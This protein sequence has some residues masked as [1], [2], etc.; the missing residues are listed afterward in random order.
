MPARPLGASA[1]ANRGINAV[2]PAPAGGTD[3]QLPLAPSDRN[4]LDWLRAFNQSTDPSQYVGQ[5]SEL[6]GFVY[7]D[8]RLPAGQFLLTRFMLTCCVADA[9][10]IGAIVEWPRAA[11]LPTNGW[12]Q[13]GGPVRVGEL[14][15]VQLP[16]IEAETVEA[17]PEPAQPYLY[18]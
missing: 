2:A 11:E 8:P 6:I 13:I 3:A 10:A 1:I 18:N 4:L 9:T 17:V 15:G 7:H 12:V 16:L 5:P 14:G